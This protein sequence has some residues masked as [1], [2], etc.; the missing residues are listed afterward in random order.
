MASPPLSLDSL[1]QVLTNNPAPG[2]L[3][4]ALSS[5]EDETC[6][7]FTQA[8]ITGDGALLSAYYSS[9]LFSHL[10]IDEM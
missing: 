5:Y 9:F 7:Q 2:A 4:D 1:R 10:L 3:Y 6:L 8:G